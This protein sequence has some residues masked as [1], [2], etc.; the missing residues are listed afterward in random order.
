MY[1]GF[2]NGGGAAS[3]SRH[4]PAIRGR[5]SAVNLRDTTRDVVGEVERQTGYM[6][7]VVPDPALATVTTV[8]M[9]GCV[10]PQLPAVYPDSAAGVW[11]SGQAFVG[12][13]V[14]Q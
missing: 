5:A 9:A 1:N 8:V 13:A 11:R 2:R 14:V 3:A 7:K 10:R 12:V 4:R 6:V